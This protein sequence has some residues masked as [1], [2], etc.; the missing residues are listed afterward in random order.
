MR[1]QILYNIISWN[2]ISQAECWVDS[3]QKSEPVFTCYLQHCERKCEANGKCIWDL[4]SA[5]CYYILKITFKQVL[6]IANA[7]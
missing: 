7:I 1:L 6:D 2:W 4:L 3:E 5:K